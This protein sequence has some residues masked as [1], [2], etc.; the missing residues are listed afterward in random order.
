M[1]VD[2]VRDAAIDV[3]MRVFQKGAFLKFALDKS[4]RRRK[5]ISQRG[6][7]FLSQLVYGTVRH[8]ESRDPP[9]YK[10]LWTSGRMGVHDESELRLAGEKGENA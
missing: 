4:L 10:V 6:A 8:I 2:P 7:R 3:L 1:P 9:K 5:N